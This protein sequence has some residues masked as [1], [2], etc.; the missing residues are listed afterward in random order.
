MAG[1]GYGWGVSAEMERRKA[2]KYTGRETL[3]EAAVSSIG[4]FEP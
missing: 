4:Y 2:S 3:K 1:E